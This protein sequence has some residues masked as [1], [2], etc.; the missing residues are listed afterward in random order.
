MLRP[1]GVSLLSFCLST[2]VAG[3]PQRVRIEDDLSD[4]ILVRQGELT[5]HV[6]KFHDVPTRL[7][8]AFPA[9]NSG[10]LL[11]F[12]DQTRLA[13]VDVLEMYAVDPSAHGIRLRLSFAG[14]T[15]S[16]VQAAL[17]SLREIRRE[18]TGPGSEQIPD[19]NGGR[20]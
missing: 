11:E 14:P 19:Q 4:S 12:D 13:A 8:I 6:L 17:G 15:V 9:G 2:A 16:I 18:P 5:A 10:A 20:A 7:L 3:E 1:L